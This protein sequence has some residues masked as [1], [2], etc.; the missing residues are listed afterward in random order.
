MFVKFLKRHPQK[1]ASA[2]TTQ[3]RENVTTIETFVQELNQA[4]KRAQTNNTQLQM[5]YSA[6][7]KHFVELK[8]EL[9]DTKLHVV[10]LNSSLHSSGGVR[11]VTFFWNCSHAN[12]SMVWS[13]CQLKY[14]CLNYSVII[15]LSPYSRGWFIKLFNIFGHPLFQKI[16]VFFLV[17]PS[18]Q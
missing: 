9:F 6:L 4:R 3:L 17:Q 18:L 15:L 12:S 8:Q 13:F 16:K 10:T 5:V 2:N 7:E 1:E 14:S 11:Q